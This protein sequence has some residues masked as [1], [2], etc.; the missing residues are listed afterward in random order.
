M[1]NACIVIIYDDLHLL[2]NTGNSL[3]RCNLKFD[4]VVAESMYIE[5]A[6]NLDTQ[7]KNCYTIK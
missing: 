4:R 7:K 1:N 3:L 5:Y 6:L 2:T